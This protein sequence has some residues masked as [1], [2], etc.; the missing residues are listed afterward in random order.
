MSE[1]WFISDT[2]FFHDRIIELAKR[3]FPSVESMNA[4]IILR[5]NELV[6]PNDNVYH[7]GDFALSQKQRAPEIFEQLKGKIHLIDGNHDKNLNCPFASRQPY[8]KITVH[9]QQISL[10]HYAGRVWDQS[11]NGAW[12]L[13]GHSHGTLSP[14]GKSV[15]VGV[16]SPW[17]TGAALYRPFH[18]E[19]IKRF[20]A[21]RSV[22]L[23]DHHNQRTT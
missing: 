10:F 11:H 12:L 3:P 4:Y 19:E 5:W 21:D 7:L 23:P 16:D 1:T 17:I 15:D 20:M 6:N 13:F 8:K 14:F 9:K 2:H 18:F 22:E